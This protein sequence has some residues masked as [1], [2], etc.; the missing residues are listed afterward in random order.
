MKRLLPAVRRLIVRRMVAASVAGCVAACLM[1]AGIGAATAST[2][3][4]PARAPRSADGSIFLSGSPGVPAANPTT[5]TLYVPVQCTTRSC[6][7]PGRVVDLINTAKCNARIR[8]DC[9]VVAKAKVGTSPLD[10]VVD[11]RTDTIYVINGTSNTVSVLNGSRCNAKLTKGCGR[12]VATVRVGKFPTSAAVNPATRTLYVAN[13]GGGSISVINAATCNA[14]TTRGC[15]GRVRTVKDK[16]GPTSIAVDMATDTVYA[17]NSGSS[18]NGDTVS[19]IDGQACNGHDGRGCGRAPRTVTVGSNTFWVAVDQA[20]DTVYAANF[21]NEFNG[22]SVSVINGARCNR[23]V[24]SGCGKTPP[25]VPTGI[26]TGFVAVDDALHTAF[27]VNA[28]DDTLSAI[29]TRTC[30]GR[31]TSGCARR[32]R[33]QQAGPIAGP[34][35]NPFPGAFALLPRLGTA[36]TLNVGG[37]A[38]ASVVSISGCNAINSKGCR[39]EAASLPSQEFLM[40]LDPATDTIYAGNL[41]LPRIDVIN[42]ATCRPDN[43]SGCA[44]VAEIPVKHPQANV[45]SIDD[46]THTLYASDPFSDTVAVINTAACNAT[47]TGGCAAH[48]HVLRIGQNPGPPVLNPATGTLYVPDGPSANQVAVINA[49]TCNATDTAGCGQAPA[50]VRVAKG[51]FSVA[52]S[53]AANTI[54]APATGLQ[55]NGHTMAVINGAT[56]DGNDHGGCGHLAATITTGFAPEGVTVNDHTHTVYV[57]INADGDVPGTVQ[58]INGAAC[59]GTRTGGCA[60]RFLTMPAGVSPSA[61]ALDSSTGV[62]YVTDFASADVTELN[63]ARC[64]AMNTRG[65]AAP[66]HQQPVGSGPLV[67]AVNQATNIIYIINNYQPGSMTIFHGRP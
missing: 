22:G 46:V 58:V 29:N 43:R 42:A 63:T 37:Q 48:P 60:G 36:Y 10:A 31:V 59:D 30:D 21:V 53:A 25:T 3:P 50:Q 49:A 45:G 47:H 66:G 11:Q 33:S 54:Y 38:I 7:T 16:A 55:F 20:T 64:N 51:T 40:T 56:C 44:P 34:G 5:G 67:I 18:L 41:N 35:F 8:T 26:G 27:A 61:L 2:S 15:R 1:L 12:P 32:P 13:T 23:R 28:G 39:R 17:A 6:K 62:L 57:A 52:V 65:C 9:R 24:T 19:V 4:G 14:E